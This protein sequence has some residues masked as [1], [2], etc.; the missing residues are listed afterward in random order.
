MSRVLSKDNTST[1]CCLLS[2]L[3]EHPPSQGLG[4]TKLEHIWQ[5]FEEDMAQNP[6][7]FEG[8]KYAVDIYSY[9]IED[10]SRYGLPPS[11]SLCG[12]EGD[13]TFEVVEGSGSGIPGI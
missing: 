11:S 12:I 7:L 3:T 5:R 9:S 10:R 1:D 6:R 2:K 13:S 4:L 8:V